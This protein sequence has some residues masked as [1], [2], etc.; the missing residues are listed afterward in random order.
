[1]ADQAD[2]TILAR[3]PLPQLTLIR[4]IWPQKNSSELIRGLLSRVQLIIKVLLLGA[5]RWGKV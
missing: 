2:Q 1:M 3:H 5:G 4:M